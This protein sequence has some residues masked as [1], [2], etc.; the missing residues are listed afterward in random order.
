MPTLRTVVPVR[1]KEKEKTRAR[2]AH[3]GPDH[4]PPPPHRGRWR[5]NGARPTPG[6]ILSA[7]CGVGPG[8]LNT[9]RYHLFTS[10]FAHGR[11]EHNR[12]LEQVLL[13]GSSYTTPVA[14]GL[15]TASGPW[16]SE[17]TCGAPSRAKNGAVWCSS[18]C[19]GGPAQERLTARRTA[20]ERG[21]EHR[22]SASGLWR[23]GESA[24]KRFPSEPS[25]CLSAPWHQFKQTLLRSASAV[26]PS[27]SRTRSSR[28]REREGCTAGALRRGVQ[29]AA[30]GPARTQRAWS[31]LLAFPR[32]LR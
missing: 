27:L 13:L 8:G 17:N 21:Q 15:K 29:P 5:E 1:K 2:H 11:C 31:V 19:T 23:L 12:K 24:F 28:E 4:C 32:T 16:R 20:D 26:K 7:L 22:A 6:G 14:G 9:L 25:K 30:T 18:S 10:G 3:G